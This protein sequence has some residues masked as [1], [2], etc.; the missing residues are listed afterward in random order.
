MFV[1]CTYRLIERKKAFEIGVRFSCPRF[2]ESLAR[3]FREALALVV[4]ELLAAL[5]EDSVAAA[6]AP[7]GGFSSEH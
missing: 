3:S 2:S 5:L 4:F 7:L 1:G 6:D